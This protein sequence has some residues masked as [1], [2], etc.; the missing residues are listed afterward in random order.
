MR[1]DDLGERIRDRCG[2]GA[3]PLCAG[4]HAAQN[5]KNAVDPHREEAPSDCLLTKGWRAGTAGT[6]TLLEVE[7]LATA[8][9][10]CWRRVAIKLNYSKM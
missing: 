3:E 4:V 8:T 10:P 9:L 1:R 6:Q 5:C 7:A 2:L